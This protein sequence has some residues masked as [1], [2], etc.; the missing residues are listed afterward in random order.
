MRANEVIKRHIEENGIKQNFVANKIGLSPELFRRSIDGKRK[1]TAD[2]LISICSV[3]S[4]QLSDFQN[5]TQQN[6]PA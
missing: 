2:E 5:V 4:L 3:L 6:K 1:I